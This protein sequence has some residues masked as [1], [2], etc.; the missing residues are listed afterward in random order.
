MRPPRAG[1]AL[2]AV[3]G[4]AAGAGATAPPAAALNPLTV[5]C[6]IA[7]AASGVAGKLCSA[8]QNGGRLLSAGK[9]LATGR[10]GGALKSIF[11]GGG[12]PVASRLSAAVTLAALGA[13]VGDAAKSA[14]SQ[15]AHVLG[16]TT[17]PQLTSTWFS[18]SYWKV[19]GVAA[20][21]TLPFLFAA[22]VQALVASDLSVLARAAF[23][24]LPLA[25]LGVAVAAPLIT[26][27]L[28]AS[29]QLCSIVASAAGHSSDRF[30]IRAGLVIGMVSGVHGS[31]FLL[32]LAGLL[33]VGVALALW[34]ELL[35]RAAAVY[36]VVLLLPLVFAAFVWPAR[37][38]WLF[39]A[40]EVLIA[41]ILSKFVIV[42]VL[43][44]G[45]AALSHSFPLGVTGTVAGLAL[46]AMAICAPWALIRLLPLTEL[47][48]G[49]VA[50]LRGE[51]RSSGGHVAGIYEAAAERSSRGEEAN[52]RD[53]DWAKTA[54][55]RMR[56]E[57]AATDPGDAPASTDE[58]PPN[59]L[60]P[61]PPGAAPPPPGAAPP[62]P[63]AA[64][65]PPGAVPPPPGPGA[66]APE[67][68]PAYEPGIDQPPPGNESSHPA[69]PTATRERS[70]GLGPIWQA[71]DFAWA[72]LELGPD[73]DWPPRVWPPEDGR[74]TNGPD[75]QPSV[76]GDEIPPTQPPPE[77]RP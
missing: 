60:Q 15:T 68:E 18:A 53:P 47:A 36:I 43:S 4:A 31:T 57:L 17:R 9:Q 52:A 74:E 14:L 23:G 19:A 41:L 16:E 65:A 3:V 35:V 59:S 32:F 39:R 63:D 21:L 8:V 25:M 1:I 77:D 10:F 76:G 55:A 20:L 48:A 64:P 12:S 42:A 66:L 72:P 27:L 71:E 5:V 51:I 26:L 49:A 29:D 2:V 75:V 7:G 44:L 61:A 24:H 6:G 37:R 30:L 46:L 62:P 54:T 11:G 22:A 69:P 50:S 67:A 56:N 38:I 28:S 33:T 45:G 13:W 58:E 34:V 73:A 40:L 70:P